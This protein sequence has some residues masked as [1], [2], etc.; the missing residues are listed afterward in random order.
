MKE[1][2]PEIFVKK[3]YRDNR[4]LKKIIYG[5]ERSSF[6]SFLENGMKLIG[7]KAI[8][9]KFCVCILSKLELGSEVR[10]LELKEV[11]QF[12]PVLKCVIA[13]KKSTKISSDVHFFVK[14][15]PGEGQKAVLKLTK[16]L[17]L[18]NICSF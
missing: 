3:S 11:G 17:A 6:C 16:P 7:V 4:L 5:S 9:L 15:S 1:K 13:L 8:M 14:Q 10:G 12:R 18:Q 2:L